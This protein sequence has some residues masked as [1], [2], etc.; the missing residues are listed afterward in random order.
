MKQEWFV[1]N[2]SCPIDHFFAARPE[3]IELGSR[4]YNDLMIENVWTNSPMRQKVIVDRCGRGHDE[5]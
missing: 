4:A 5:G 1:N 2:Q 3:Y